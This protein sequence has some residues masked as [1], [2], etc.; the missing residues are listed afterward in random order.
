M[1]PRRLSRLQRN[2]LA[3]LFA[4]H[5]RTWGHVIM[6]H[7]A[8]VQALGHNKSTLSH[9]LRTLETRGLIRIG[10]MP[11]G[12]ADLVDLTSEGLKWASNLE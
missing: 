4:Q 9:S 7:Y 11:G 12:K 2:I 10:R 8:L 3:G 1:A 5:Q 6:G